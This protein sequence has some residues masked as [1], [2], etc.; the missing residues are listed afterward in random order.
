MPEVVFGW[1]A[2]S[3]AGWA[4]RRLG[5]QRPF[6]VTDAGLVQAGWWSELAGHLAEA[7]LRGTVLQELT[8]NPKDHEVAAGTERYMVIGCHCIVVL[9]SRSVIHGA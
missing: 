4:A 8:P 9:G 6:V 2:L 1:G 3:E 5:A 7:G